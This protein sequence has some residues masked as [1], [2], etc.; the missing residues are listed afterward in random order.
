MK[1]KMILPAV[2]LCGLFASSA[3]AVTPITG[4]T[5]IGNGV[6]SPSTK[7]GISV[8]SGASSYA[9]TSCHLNGT[10]E[11]GVGGGLAFTGDA[12]KVVSK[13]I[14][15]QSTSAATGVPDSPVD[16]T[17]LGTGWQ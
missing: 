12:S 9:A 15:T 3:F 5:T 4:S 11:F 16:A 6:F 17:S 10:L 8:A 13:T 2:A 7:V 1:T 14:P